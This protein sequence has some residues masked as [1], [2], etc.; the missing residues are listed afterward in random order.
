MS[1]NSTMACVNAMSTMSKLPVPNGSGAVPET[2]RMM[3]K[4][5]TNV[6]S[7]SAA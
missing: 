4:T 5:S 1:T 2:A 6:P 3:N 7:T